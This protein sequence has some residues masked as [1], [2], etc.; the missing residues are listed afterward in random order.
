MKDQEEASFVFLFLTLVPNMD[1]LYEKIKLENCS[2]PSQNREQ[3]NS[4]LTVIFYNIT[5]YSVGKFFLKN[6]N[7]KKYKENKKISLCLQNILNVSEEIWFH[8]TP[9]IPSPCTPFLT[10]FVLRK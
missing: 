3:G 10:G 5:C 2:A 4:T 9:D 1:H 8:R 7:L 6:P